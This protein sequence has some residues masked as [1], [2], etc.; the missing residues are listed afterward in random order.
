MAVAE[1]ILFARTA[2]PLRRAEEIVG[3]LHVQAMMPMTRFAA[4][5]HEGM[6]EFR[7]AFSICS[8]FLSRSRVR[9][10][11]DGGRLRWQL[12]SRNTM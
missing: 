7:L 6:V 9:W 11:V 4:F 2:L 8:P 5:V 12:R 1:Q 3:G 10:K